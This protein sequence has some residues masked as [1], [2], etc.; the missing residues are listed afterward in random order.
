MRP[1][2]GLDR[3]QPRAQVRRLPRSPSLSHAPR[4]PSGFL[5]GL[6]GQMRASRRAGAPPAC[7]TPPPL[8]HIASLSYG[9]FPQR[10]EGPARAAARPPELAAFGTVFAL[11][12]TKNGSVLGRP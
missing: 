6:S 8:T 3:P 4:P 2:T 7:P 1:Q 11:Y 5:I 10:R 9:S 12:P